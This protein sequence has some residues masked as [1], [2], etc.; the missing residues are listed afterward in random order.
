MI[1]H[2]LIKLFAKDKETKSAAENKITSLL[3]WLKKAEQLMWT[4]G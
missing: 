2:F 4:E 3:S 1:P